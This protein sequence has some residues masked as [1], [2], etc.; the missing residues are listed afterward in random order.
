MVKSNAAITITS[1]KYAPE[2]QRLPFI[3]EGKYQ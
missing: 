2:Y 3:E 1:W